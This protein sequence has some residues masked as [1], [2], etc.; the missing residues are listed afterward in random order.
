VL[1][2]S[3]IDPS[4]FAA[5]ALVAVSGLLPDK[6]VGAAER[7]A[8]RSLTGEW[9]SM[10]KDFFDRDKPKKFRMYKRPSDFEAISDKLA[11][12]KFD[13]MMATAKFADS[14]ITQRYI[15]VVRNA[16]EYIRQHIHILEEQTF[17]GPKKFEPGWVTMAD[18]AAI[19]AVVNG[20]SRL[21]DEILS[22]TVL[23][24]QVSAFKAIYPSLFTMLISIF[25]ERK[26]LEMTKVL[27][28]AV[29]WWKERVIRLVYSIPMGASITEQKKSPPGMQSSPPQ[30]QPNTQ[31]IQ[32]NFRTP[33]QT[34]SRIQRIEAK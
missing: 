34:T 20:P 19:Y 26:F 9:R 6:P 31:N 1:E 27:S 8:A 29:P 22:A 24:E 3:Q 16:Q 5:E 7:D 11:S 14:D 13:V 2:T 33:D 28:Y 12:G 18:T 32:V 21:L 15:Q 10:I 23:E 17:T 30:P 4:Q 25:E